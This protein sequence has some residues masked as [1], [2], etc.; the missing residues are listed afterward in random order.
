MAMTTKDHTPIEIKA[1]QPRVSIDFASD[2]LGREQ[3]V[4]FFR[5]LSQ[6][7]ENT[8]IIS[9][10]VILH[11]VA[12]AATM[13]VNDCW[14]NS[15]RD[16]ALKPLGRLSFQPLSENPLLGPS[17]SLRIAIIYVFSAFSGSFVASLFLLDRSSVASSGALFGLLGAMLSGLTRNWKFHS[18]KLSALLAILSISVINLALGLLPYVN[19]FANIGGFI[20]GFLLG[21]ALLFNPLLGKMAQNK[22]GLFEY[23]VKCSVKLRQKLDKPVLRTVS[24][25]LFSLLRDLIRGV[26]SI[27]RLAGVIVAVLHGVNVS[28]Y[29][30]WCQYVDCVPSKWWSCNDKPMHCETEVTTGRLTLTCEGSDKFRVFP[31][32][33]ISQARIEDLCNL[34]CS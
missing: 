28:K 1:P 9:L 22:G 26:S 3:R 23:D 13:I 20:S 30:G 15:H 12:F 14:K 6:R 31:F 2:E 32:T 8:W 4:P 29:C 10:F 7:R 16:C 27:C 5:P 11:L 17:S 24:L 19:N 25:V 33:D 18:N 34:I 21:F